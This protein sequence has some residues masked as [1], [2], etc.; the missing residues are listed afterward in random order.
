[1][2]V[3][4]QAKQTH[5]SPVGGRPQLHLQLPLPLLLL[6]VCV[7]ERERERERES[8]H[9]RMVM[10]AWLEEGVVAAIANGTLA[11]HAM[12]GFEKSLLPSHPTRPVVS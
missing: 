5:L 12:A 11:C 9:G 10:M 6:H 4:C 3:R 2:S 7:C 8:R 1:M